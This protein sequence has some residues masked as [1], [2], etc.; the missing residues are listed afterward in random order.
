MGSFQRRRLGVYSMTSTEDVGELMVY[1][2]H[3][4]H[5]TAGM[6]CSVLNSSVFLTFKHA[7]LCAIRCG[8]GADKEI[9]LPD[10]IVM[11]YSN[12]SVEVFRIESSY[13]SSENANTTR[14]STCK[15]MELHSMKRRRIGTLLG[16]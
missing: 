14:E 16:I 15:E 5:T 4:Y 6:P 2:H 8:G 1:T 3:L 13:G 10:N 9:R 7:C 11:A 12:Q